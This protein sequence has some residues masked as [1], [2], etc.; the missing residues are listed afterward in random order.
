MLGTTIHPNTPNKRCGKGQKKEIYYMPQAC[1]G[2]R[3][4]KHF[5]SFSGY[6]HEV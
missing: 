1:P 5:S 6:R 2:K 3:Q 4:S